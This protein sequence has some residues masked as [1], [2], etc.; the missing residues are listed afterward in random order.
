MEEKLKNQHNE[1]FKIVWPETDRTFISDGTDTDDLNRYVVLIYGDNRDAG[2]MSKAMPD[3]KLQLIKGSMNYGLNM[4]EMDNGHTTEEDLVKLFSWIKIVNENSSEVPTNAAVMLSCMPQQLGMVEKTMQAEFCNAGTA[5]TVWHKPNK[6]QKNP[7][8][9]LVSDLECM[10]KGWRSATGKLPADMFRYKD[11]ETKTRL[12]QA[13]AVINKLQD[14]ERKGLQQ[15]GGEP[16]GETRIFVSI[17]AC[18]LEITS[19]PKY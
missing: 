5:I 9:G 12:F 4:F 16:T 14:N 6:F 10:V 19:F 17:K 8:V 15:D 13:G 18:I 11:S 2:L 3:V 1:V 7:A